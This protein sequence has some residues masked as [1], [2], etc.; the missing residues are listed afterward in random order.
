MTAHLQPWVDVV[1]KSMALGVLTGMDL[2]S[3]WESAKQVPQV[4]EQTNWILWFW[5]LGRQTETK[6]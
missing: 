4:M 6:Q 1:T 2:W 5:R 3:A